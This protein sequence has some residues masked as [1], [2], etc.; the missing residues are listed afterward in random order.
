[1]KTISIDIETF[2][3]IDLFE[4]GVYRYT[5]APDFQVLLIAYAKTTAKGR[6]ML[7]L[8]GLS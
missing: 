4:A 3:S 7:K 1:M 8:L 2:S 6:M 5:E